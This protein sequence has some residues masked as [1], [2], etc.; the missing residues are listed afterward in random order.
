MPVTKQTYTAGTG[1][2][3]SDLAGLFRSAFIDAGLMTEWFDS[4][5]TGNFQVRVIELNYDATKTYGKAYYVFF[6]NS[7]SYSG[8]SIASGWNTSTKTQAGTQFV[9]FH[10]PIA[11][12]SNTANWIHATRF[13][14]SLVTGSA[15]FVHRYTSGVDTKQSWFVLQQG[16]NRSRPFS[17]LHSQSSLYSW[18]DLSKG[19]VDP[20]VELVTRAS[21]SA[22]SVM[23][24]EQENIRRCLLKGHALSGNT[25]TISGNIFHG[26]NLGKYAYAGVGS[27]SNSYSVNTSEVF[28]Q[29]LGC[30]LLPV[31]RSASNPA[32]SSDYIPICTGVPWSSYSPTVLASDFAVYMHYADNTINFQDRFVVTPSV[33]EW[34]VLNFT[35]SATI[36]TGVSP[37][38]LARV[39]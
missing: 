19:I 31:G 5:S 20:F 6:F 12:F 23:F 28:G 21:N 29:T 18:L 39:V 22:G 16:G 15:V 25:N 34:E 13:E 1:W 11:S 38:F 33:E 27:T 3:A 36:G 4:T 10:V 8:F 7:G 26:N 32:Y 30:T 24:V 14:I 17:L 35:N 2:T 9:D 37:T